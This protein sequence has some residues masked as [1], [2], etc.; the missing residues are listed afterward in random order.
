[1]PTT[2]AGRMG[3]L[4]EQDVT[5]PIVGYAQVATEQ[6]IDLA[7]TGLTYAVP[8]S[9]ADLAVGERVIVPLGR[10]DRRVA[11]FGIALSERS[12]V[13]N[14]K[15][16]LSRDA[17][18]LTLRPELIEL[19]RWMAGYYCTA[20]VMVLANILPEAVKRGIG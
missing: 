12:D 20:L 9:M 4:F 17:S 2:I 16:F 8:E 19:A 1:K 6:G 10:G 7:A 5:E 15:S 14:V 11:G 18:A 13:D 3:Q